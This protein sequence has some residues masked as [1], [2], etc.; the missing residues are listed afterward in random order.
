MRKNIIDKAV[1]SVDGKKVPFNEVTNGM[2]VTISGILATT[3]EE[4]N[5]EVIFNDD[6]TVTT[7]YGEEFEVLPIEARLIENA[8][9][10][11]VIGVES[12][13][14][15]FFSTSKGEIFELLSS[16]LDGSGVPV[17]IR[18]IIG[19]H[20]RVGGGE[21]TTSLVR[22]VL[23]SDGKVFILTRNTAYLVVWP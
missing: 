10:I 3:G 4:V 22:Q 9:P 12:N 13:Y 19:H 8:I 2:T 1:F 23:Q 16:L 20:Y 14:L 6:C 11:R 15:N 18:G 5:L 17:R 21:V 7:V